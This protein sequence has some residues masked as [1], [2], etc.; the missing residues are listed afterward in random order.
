MCVKV[1]QLVYI[2]A[3]LNLAA[4]VKSRPDI[5][6]PGISDPTQFIPIDGAIKAIDEKAGLEPGVANNHKLVTGSSVS[7]GD[8]IDAQSVRLNGAGFKFPVF[9]DFKTNA[10]LLKENLDEIKIFGLPDKEYSLFYEFTPKHL[11]IY[12]VT[13]EDELTHYE[14][15]ISK[16]S[17][18]G[19]W[20]VPIGGY[21]VSYFKAFKEP[22]A[23][24]R[25]TN[26]K[27]FKEVAP[28]N[29]KSLAT[30]FTYDSKS[31]VLFEVA[32][33]KTNIYPSDYFDGDWYFATTIV[34]TKPGEESNLGYF[35]S[36]ID[37]SLRKNATRVKFVR[38]LEFLRAVNTVIDSRIEVSDDQL[39]DVINIPAKWLD[40]TVYKTD[41]YEELKEEIDNSTDY[42]N[43]PFVRLDFKMTKSLIVADNSQLDDYFN[44][45]E[46]SDVSYAKDTFSFTLLRISTGVKR[47][48]SF[49]RI[50]EKND[51][52]P[53]VYSIDDS[54]IYG[55]FATKIERLLDIGLHRRTDYEQNLLANRFNPKK[56]I[57]FRF[58]KQT[59]TAGTTDF[60]GL[61]I[62]YRKIGEN[63]VKYWNQAFK[64]IGAPNEIRL[65]KSVE[66]E[67]GDFDANTINI[68]TNL[69]AD[70]SGGVG[71]TIADPMTGEIINGTVNVYTATTIAGT[72]NDL[73]DLL[74]IERGLVND[75][76][77]SRAIRERG[78]KPGF[79]KEVDY[80]CPEII[81]FAKK[82]K[83]QL[84]ENSEAENKVVFSCLEKIV[85]KRIEA[86]VTHEMGHT[87]GLRHNFYGSFDKK[88]SFQ[89]ISDLESIYPRNE[90]P[91][92]YAQNL[93]KDDE[94]MLLNYS[95]IMDYFNV[96]FRSDEG[97]S[98]SVPSAYDISA[99]AYLYMHKLPL[100]GPKLFNGYV[101]LDPEK[102]IGENL[103][104]GIKN[105]RSTLYCKDEQALNRTKPPAIIDSGCA[106]HDK[107][108]TYTEILDYYFNSMRDSL[109]IESKK[110]D[111][112]VLSNPKGFVM[113]R[114]TFMG[115]VYMDWRFKLSKLMSDPTNTRLI[116]YSP[117]SFNDLLSKVKSSDTRI[118]D[119]A[120]LSK[121]YFDYLTEISDM[122]NYYCITKNDADEVNIREF[123]ILQKKLI[124]FTPDS[125]IESCNDSIIA[126]KLEGEQ[127]IGSMGLPIK[128]IQFSQKPEDSSESFD[129][130]GVGEIREHA[131]LH[132]GVLP[133]LLYFN[134]I[135]GFAPSILDEPALY[136][137]YKRKVESRILDGLNITDQLN[138]A[139]EI[140]DTDLKVPSRKRFN[141]YIEENS[142]Y[143]KAFVTL[144]NSNSGTDSSGSKRNQLIDF[145][146][147]KTSNVRD[148]PA[149]ATSVNISNVYFYAL[150]NSTWSVNLINRYKQI[151][152]PGDIDIGIVSPELKAVFDM[153]VTT[154]EDLPVYER[155]NYVLSL[156]TLG[157]FMQKMSNVRQQNQSNSLAVSEL[158]LAFGNYMEGAYNLSQLFRSEQINQTTGQD[159]F[160]FKGEPLSVAKLTNYV[161]KLRL[162]GLS[163]QLQA[164]M[165]FKAPLTQEA[166]LG[167]YLRQKDPSTYSYW[168]TKFEQNAEDLTDFEVEELT[169]YKAYL[170][171]RIGAG[172]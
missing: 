152:N 119:D 110:L 130:L 27:N 6:A 65:D 141:K 62:D 157:Q 165:G 143:D 56:D 47:K 60:Y 43:R 156:E 68:I 142:I 22:D 12:K 4:C 7:R 21:E 76:V 39:D 171:N 111:S 14:K 70:G 36:S 17:S 58:S 103:A 11:K 16:Q 30:H 112:I 129:V 66:N 169:A 82:T 28:E 54:K 41:G 33:D 86:I 26:I 158:N 148:I 107:G 74:K 150:P 53:M 38:S 85:P 145:D 151:N 160:I 108:Q 144:V 163:E 49:Q 97:V 121:R 154:A 46:V 61:K 153:L 55:Y 124:N 166:V 9:V 113:Q 34:S 126:E 90:F 135:N 120:N 136:Q 64:V 138:Y 93:P 10:P 106:L 44:G 147:G 117:Q 40:Y 134:A 132:L 52:K 161:E 23:D 102:D 164:E 128:P 167:N 50:P 77:F 170:E 59:P 114:I 80:L 172:R 3:I 84:L 73:R 69:A 48:Y 125:Q 92:L 131:V 87:L 24:N 78:I 15:P 83:G 116:G 81:K 155:E 1:K 127:V 29:Y 89:T 168:Q 100:D 95:S 88:N 71:P 45:L 101:K 51:Y 42:K 140:L 115:V 31:F 123:S 57:V 109:L 159:E 98:L 63:S 72:S 104:S 139:L 32:E 146:M 137:N 91:D 133:P 13:P 75:T 67:L 35:D 94:S 18:D 162:E 96:W 37:A 25:A 105:S 5:Y 122:S 2:L 79:R 118:K 149:L 8:T 99:L 20:L 19:K